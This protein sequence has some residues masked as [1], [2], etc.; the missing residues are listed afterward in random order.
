MKFLYI[1][2]ICFFLFSC[3]SEQNKPAD[4]ASKENTKEMSAEVSKELK[5][6]SKLITNKDRALKFLEEAESGNFKSISSLLSKKGFEIK[7]NFL[8][9]DS[10]SFMNVLKNEAEKN[11]DFQIYKAGQQGNLCFT[12]SKCTW[13][14][15]FDV[16][17]YFF[18]EKGSITKVISFISN[19][20]ITDNSISSGT[21]DI[22]NTPK[23][24]L[25]SKI[26][27]KIAAYADSKEFKTHLNKAKAKDF[28]FHGSPS[29]VTYEKLEKITCEGDLS[30]V[31]YRGKQNGKDVAILDFYKFKDQKITEQWQLISN[32]VENI[33]AAKNF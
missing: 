22:G 2:T 30:L 20:S 24:G 18:F 32:Q 16:V 3:G 19:T 33:A 9:N 10:A 29:P 6:P 5:A 31:L 26:S 7:H 17:D 11:L 1:V 12:H 27:K 4:L 15:P 28:V 13:K 8:R 14:E 25:N 23:T 21:L